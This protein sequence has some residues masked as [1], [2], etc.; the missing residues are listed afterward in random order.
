M[1]LSCERSARKLLDVYILREDNW[2]EEGVQPAIRGCVW[3]INPGDL[4][5]LSDSPQA[6]FQAVV[7]IHVRVGILGPPVGFDLSGPSELG[8]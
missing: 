5:C 1:F 2:L 6:R 7:Q 8:C 3:A 4:Y